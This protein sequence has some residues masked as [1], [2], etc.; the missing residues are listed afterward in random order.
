MD[1]SIRESEPQ[2]E[3]TGLRVWEGGGSE[4]LPV[5]GRIGIASLDNIIPRESEQTSTWSLITREFGELSR[6]GKQMTAGI[7]LA[8]APFCARAQDGSKRVA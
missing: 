2:G 6:E 4:C 8:G 1:A 5:M 3:P 7:V